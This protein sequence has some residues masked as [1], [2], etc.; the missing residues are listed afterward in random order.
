MYPSSPSLFLFP[1]LQCKRRDKFLFFHR[2]RDRETRSHLAGTLFSILFV[3]IAFRNNPVLLS[4]KYI[5]PN[6]RLLQYI[7]LAFLATT[8]CASP[9]GYNLRR[10]DDGGHGKKTLITTEVVFTT[11]LILEVDI[12]DFTSQDL[13]EPTQTPSLE[14]GVVNV[15]VT[16]TDT[17]TVNLDLAPST[18]QS[19]YPLP[20]PT[21][22]TPEGAYTTTTSPSPET[23]QGPNSQPINVSPPPGPGPTLS[24]VPGDP[25]SSGLPLPTYSPQPGGPVFGENIPL[26]IERNK[27][28]STTKKGD[29][30]DPAVQLLAC[31][32]TMGGSILQC[33]QGSTYE[34]VLPCS[35]GTK[36]FATPK[37]M[38]SGV[39]VACD[40]EEDAAAKFGMTVEELIQKV[41]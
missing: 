11:T 6:M 10:H 18:I 28:F 33:G 41:K 27:G 29:K 20:T 22:P 37:R 4:P 8:A 2:V 38:T 25:T 5:I 23:T 9:V 14:D 39:S 12:G 3:L 17:G 16:T 40:K 1:F 19:S 26:A 31:E 34:S 15:T 35:H 13:I 36:C 7:P 32:G 30:C 24:P 21:P